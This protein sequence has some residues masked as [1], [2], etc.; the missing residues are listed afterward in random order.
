MRILNRKNLHLINHFSI[1]DLWGNI[2]KPILSVK[3][4]LFLV[5]ILGIQ[6]GTAQYKTTEIKNR[7]EYLCLDKGLQDLIEIDDE[8]IK[9]FASNKIKSENPEFTLYWDEVPYFINISKT[10]TLD[11]LVKIYSEK[12]NIHKKK[13]WRTDPN[14]LNNQKLKG[15]KGK[16]IA[17]DP[18]HFAGNM[19]TARIEQKYLDFQIQNAGGETKKIQIAEGMLTWQTA[20]L[21]KKAL[22]AEGAEVML[23]RPEINS[24]SFGTSYDKWFEKE[25]QKNLDSLKNCKKISGQEHKKYMSASKK[26]FF[27]DFF[28]DYELANRV[29]IMNAFQPDLSIIIHYNVD[30]KNTDWKKPSDK[31]FTMC[32][33][34]G[35][36]T[37]D[38]FEKTAQKINFLRLL[39]SDDLEQSEKISKHTVNEFS[40]NLAIKIAEADDAD[41]LKQKCSRTK[42]PGVFCRNLALCRNVTSPLVYGECLYQDNLRECTELIKTD[43]IYSNIR[44]SQR[45]KLVSD[46]YLNAIKKY[47]EEY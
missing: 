33:I 8:S 38:N 44:T 21:L 15:L 4:V 26:Q 22:E 45:V 39:V 41:Y 31:N 3:P 9:L 1:Y 17:I 23:T 30:E 16:K 10:L 7:I 27:W 37:L 2:E 36:M 24:T 18:G 42:T 43:R 46:S 32:F 12:K 14:K 34:G 28:R 20:Y 6:N 29:K 13:E 40:K 35:G 11:S 47:F 25:K 19:A 5:F